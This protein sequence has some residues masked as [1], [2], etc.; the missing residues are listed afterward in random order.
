MRTIGKG[1]R[2]QLAKISG[3]P[4]PGVYETDTTFVGPE[5]AGYTESRGDLTLNTTLYTNDS[6]HRKT[7]KKRSASTDRF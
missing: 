3:T 5:L 1:K 7:S 4:G 6:V 2:S